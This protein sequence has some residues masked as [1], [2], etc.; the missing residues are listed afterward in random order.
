M[1]SDILF[2]FIFFDLEKKSIAIKNVDILGFENTSIHHIL[3]RVNC[4]I[5]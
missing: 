2:T 5:Y 4:H 1:I 3:N